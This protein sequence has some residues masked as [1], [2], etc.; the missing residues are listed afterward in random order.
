[1]YYT[2]VFVCTA[3]K[4]KTQ[5]ES[6]TWM[7]LIGISYSLNILNLSLNWLTRDSTSCEEM[8]V[9]NA[10]ADCEQMKKLHACWHDWLTIPAT[11]TKPM[12]NYVN[13]NLVL[14]FTCHWPFCFTTLMTV[15][16]P[17]QL[18]EWSVLLHLRHLLLTTNGGRRSCAMTHST[19][20]T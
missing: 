19:E 8:H 18:W 9:L 15:F 1:M 4:A 7:E 2:N 16:H 20:F 3:F 10:Y 6:H 17:A 13:F 12:A 5:S 11:W 14:V